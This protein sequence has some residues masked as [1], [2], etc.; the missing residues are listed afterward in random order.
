MDVYIGYI[1]YSTDKVQYQD[2]CLLLQLDKFPV[3]FPLV[4]QTPVKLYLQVCVS[5]V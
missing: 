1:Q 5:T 3:C 2:S 4:T